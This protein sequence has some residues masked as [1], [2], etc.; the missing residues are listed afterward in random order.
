MRRSESPLERTLWLLYV[1]AAMCFLPALHFYY[2]GEEAIFPISSLEMWH[3]H[4]WFVQIMYGANVRHNP[5]FNWLIMLF[6]DV[7]G[8]NHVLAVAR[9]LSILATLG[10]SWVLFWLARRFSGDR[11]FALFA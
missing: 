3:E 7:A 10:S 8:W 4:S 11:P 9:A 2:V 6:S 1:L 5:L